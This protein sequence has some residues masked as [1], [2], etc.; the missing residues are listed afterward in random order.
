MA[1]TNV[2]TEELC[3]A[4]NIS[5]STARRVLAKLE[6]QKLIK[7][8]HG[9]AYAVRDG[10]EAVENEVHA[11]I[12]KN[13]PKKLAIAREACSRIQEDSTVILLGGTTVYAMCRFLKGRRLN[14]ITNS[15]LVLSELQKEKNIRVILLGGLF[16]EKEFEVGGV[17]TNI[18][19]RHIRADYLFMGAMSFNEK[20]GFTTEDLESLELYQTCIQSSN[21]VYILADSSKYGGQGT[22]VVATHTDGHCLITDN[23]LHVDIVKLLLEK[24]IKIITAKGV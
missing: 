8:Y 15:L 20:Q 5:E 9:G 3:N 11:R 7:R 13:W 21:Q 23:E 2:S 17:L 14:I 4:F 24:G 6:L 22:A 16:N 18:G 19:M 1:K 12:E 10:M